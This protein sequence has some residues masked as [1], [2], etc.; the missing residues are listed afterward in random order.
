VKLLS[1]Y[2]L[3]DP[4]VIQTITTCLG[5]LRELNQIPEVDVSS[6]TGAFTGDRDY[7]LTQAPLLKGRLMS[8]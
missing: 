7:L 6:I 2:D 8:N 4:K 5:K 1:R 3:K